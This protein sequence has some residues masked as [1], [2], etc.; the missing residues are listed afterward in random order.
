MRVRDQRPIIADQRSIRPPDATTR[1]SNNKERPNA[2]DGFRSTLTSQVSAESETAAPRASAALL[3]SDFSI[4][5]AQSIAVG[6]VI[7]ITPE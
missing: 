6:H 3:R 7:Q 2:S 5:G 4:S 1:P